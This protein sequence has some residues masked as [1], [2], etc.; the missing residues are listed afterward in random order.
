MSKSIKYIIILIFISNCSFTKNENNKNENLVDI[1]PKNPPI[2]KEFNQQLK[3]KEL[4]TFKQKPFL[5]N[6]SNNNGNINFVSNFLRQ[7]CQV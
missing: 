4:D 5:K 7:L 1:F 3:I 6:N 2:E